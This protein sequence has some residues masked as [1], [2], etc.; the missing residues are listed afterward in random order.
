[1]TVIQLINILKQFDD[2]LDVVVEVDQDGFYR[3]IETI[4]KVVDIFNSDQHV[5][6]LEVVTE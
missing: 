5:I 3:D 6:R 2:D 1:M 4:S